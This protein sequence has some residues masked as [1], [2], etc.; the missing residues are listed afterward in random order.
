[1]I[2]S[3]DAAVTLATVFTLL[4]DMTL[5][6]NSDMFNFGVGVSLISRLGS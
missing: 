1:M 3:L 4:S 2:E 6:E 5:T